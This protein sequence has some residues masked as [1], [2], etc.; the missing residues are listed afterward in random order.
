MF[1]PAKFLTHLV[2]RL[3]DGGT[4]ELRHEEN[5]MISLR[6]DG[7]W[8]LR[9]ND[10]ENGGQTMLQGTEHHLSV[11]RSGHIVSR[12]LFRI[13]ERCESV[14]SHPPTANSKC[15]PSPRSQRTSGR[16]TRHP[17]VALR[18][19]FQRCAHRTQRTHRNLGTHLGCRRLLKPLF[20]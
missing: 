3:P 17:R 1:Y 19:L 5:V 20:S 18:S 15:R 11:S 4:D 10:P 14:S 9:Y 2:S 7:T 13:G 12:L 8:A 6:D 16:P